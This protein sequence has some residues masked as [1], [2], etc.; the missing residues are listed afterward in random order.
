MEIRTLIIAILV[1]GILMLIYMRKSILQLSTT[2]MFCLFLVLSALNIVVEMVEYGAFV[3]PDESNL[4]LQ[5]FSRGL[6]LITLLVTVFSLCIY[7]YSRFTIKRGIPVKNAA[8]SAIPAALGFLLIILSKVLFGGTSSDILLTICYIIGMLYSIASVVLA[9]AYNGRT[10]REVLS[11]IVVS[12]LVWCAMFIFQIIRK[13]TQVSSVA[14]TASALIIYIFVENPKDYYEKSIPGVRNKDAFI[15]M[16]AERFARPKTF[17][18][19]SVI[20]IEKNILFTDSARKALEDEQKKVAEFARSD[21]QLSAYLSSWNTLSFMTGRADVVERFMSAINLY[22]GIGAESYRF[23][24]SVVE[25]PRIVKELDKAMQILTYVSGEYAYSQSSPNIVID[26]NIVDKM[27]YRN[28]I[29]DVVRQA[30]K[31]KSFDVYYQPI[32]SVK[33]GSF[34]SAEALVRLRRRDGEKYISPE[35]F[36]PIAERC[37]LVQ[38]IDDLVF[39]KVCSFIAKENLISYGIKTIEVNLSGNEAVDAHTHE[40]LFRKMEKYHIPPNYINFEITDTSHITGDATFKENFTK[41]REQ[42]FTFSMDDFG[43]GDSN[44]LELLKFDYVLIKMD[45]EFIWNCLDPENPEKLNVLKHTIDFMKKNGLHVLAEGVE[46]LEQARI[47]IDNG[48]EYLQGFYY[49]RPVPENDYIEFLN[50]QKGLV[51]KAD[52]TAN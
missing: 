51:H 20:F 3:Y 22:K 48:V 31:D 43:V 45:R 37:G 4:W 27:V 24:F 21:Y 26:E 12:H 38:E 14:I 7:T 46:T 50:A 33:E 40:R 8:L 39:E 19:M 6:Y 15:A 10:K 35:D 18:I 41:M 44:I 29:E 25:A 28:T 49:S 52:G 2:R 11:A 34:S 9:C 36:I 47:L 42:G 1:L 30:V 17:F 16:L 23:T 5:G 32:L 13:G